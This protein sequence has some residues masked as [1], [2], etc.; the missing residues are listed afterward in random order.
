[1]DEFCL[2]MSN[3]YVVYT[4]KNQVDHNLWGVYSGGCATM[5]KWWSQQGEG[6]IP[7]G[8]PRLVLCLVDVK[9]KQACR[10]RLF[11]MQLHQY[12]W[13]NGQNLPIQPNRHNFGTNDGIVMCFDIQNAQNLCCLVYLMTGGSVKAG[14]KKGTY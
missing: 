11:P 10:H 6:L 4:T 1:M 8:L 12:Y 9:K 5:L 14:D 13:S 3:P 2:V 7:M